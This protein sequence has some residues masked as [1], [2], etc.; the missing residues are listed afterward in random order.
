MN[1]A[2]PRLPLWLTQ[3]YPAMH[4]RARRRHATHFHISLRLSSWTRDYFLAASHAGIALQGLSRLKAKDVGDVRNLSGAPPLLLTMCITLQSPLI[5]ASQMG[6][7][8]P[9]AEI[10][11][12]WICHTMHTL[13]KGH[14]CS[15][16]AR[17]WIFII[18]DNDMKLSNEWDGRGRVG[19]GGTTVYA[20]VC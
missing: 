16:C 9:H 20:T 18:S 19:G 8:A 14:R 5:S 2:G 13:R 3:L 1:N 17:I 7:L 12:H 10:M 4:K 15:V 11:R 6:R